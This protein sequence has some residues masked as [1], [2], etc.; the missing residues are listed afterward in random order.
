MK[1][2]G[3]LTWIT[4]GVDKLKFIAAGEADL[5]RS[6]ASPNTSVAPQHCS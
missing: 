3:E 4:L 1:V 6:D 2:G 5:Q